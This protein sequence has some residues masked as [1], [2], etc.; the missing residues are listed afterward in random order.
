[1]LTLFLVMA[2]SMPV[3]VAAASLLI[4]GRVPPLTRPPS[5]PLITYIARRPLC[6]RW[7]VQ[8]RFHAARRLYARSMSCV[9][10]L[11]DADKEV[12]DEA[13]AAEGERS[14]S[15]SIAL[16]NEGGSPHLFLSCSF[17]VT[18]VME[19][20]NEVSSSLITWIKE[21]G[22]SSF[23]SIAPQSDTYRDC[24]IDTT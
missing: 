15:S 1:M 4:N 10:S 20:D 13:V 3:L 11:L 22:S 17:S 14:P 21:G 24:S 9:P 16:V 18:V 8:S 6:C 23:S 12:L 2:L 5:N 7:G 19:E